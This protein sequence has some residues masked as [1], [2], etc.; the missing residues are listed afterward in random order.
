M[1]IS[2]LRM[3]RLVW[4]ILAVFG[5]AL[6]QVSPVELPV[7]KA[8]VC[9]CCQDGGDCGMPDCALPPAPNPAPVFALQSPAPV[10]RFTIKRATPAPRV[11]AEK[12]YVR[13]ESRPAVAP[14]PGAIAVIA[15]AA[16]VPLFRAHCSFLL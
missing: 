12:F 15:P 16:S 6:A 10:V 13:F 3:K 4:L 2:S 5:T 7:T 11:Q 14:A 8:E 9:P 1:A